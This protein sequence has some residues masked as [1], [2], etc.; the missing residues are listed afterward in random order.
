MSVN[1]DVSAL[2]APDYAQSN[3]YQAQ[4]CT[5]LERVGVEVTLTP[6]EGLFPLIKP[7]FRCSRPD[8]V[9]I[10]WLISFYGTDRSPIAVAL[11]VRLMIELTILRLLGCTIV[12][13][14]H[15][16][17]SHEARYPRTD[18]LLRFA[19]SRLANRVI[20]HCE[21]AV[22]IVLREYRIS[23]AQSKKI[24]VIPH[25]H[26]IDWYP[27]DVTKR[28]A[29]AALDIDDDA[30]VFLYFGIIREYKNVPGLVD[31]FRDMED[32]TAR[33][34][35][36]GNPW[37]DELRE[38]IIERSEDDDRIH[39]ELSYIPDEDVQRYMQAAD[40]VVLPF[41]SV[42]TS[43]SALLAMSFGNALVLP[44]VGC[45]A[46]LVDAN[47]AI[48]YE[49][50]ALREALNVARTRKGQLETMGFHNLSIARQYGWEAIAAATK[51]VYTGTPSEGSIRPVPT[52]TRDDA[53]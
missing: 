51:S 31:A 38:A 53:N 4:L 22:E 1:T 25:G 17:H 10:H 15:N 11:A 45:P 9:H 18:R 52:V 44:N 20:V 48:V 3:P 30:T 8:I 28:E 36:V 6:V 7:W 47:G 33:L 49:D 26:Y 35:I 19:T 50:N 21:R 14:V 24:D 39:L 29:R 2:M 41:D 5:A 34:L 32:E 37:T 13:T 43:G 40:L 27:S 16:L 46:E 12:W 23:P 42:L